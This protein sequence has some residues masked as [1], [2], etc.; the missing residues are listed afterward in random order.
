MHSH[1]DVLQEKK[2]RT[3]GSLLHARQWQHFYEN[4]SIADAEETLNLVLQ[5]P[6]DGA[7]AVNNTRGSLELLW[8]K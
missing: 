5:E 8:I 4:M 6:L 7:A 1:G 2:K 3:Y